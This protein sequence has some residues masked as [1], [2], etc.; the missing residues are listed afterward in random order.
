MD[1]GVS[2]SLDE[3]VTIKEEGPLST[4]QEEAA[5]EEKAAPPA[6]TAPSST[7]VSVVQDEPSKM[8]VVLDVCSPTSRVDSES[9][10]T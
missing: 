2:I 5:L 4:V 1:E 3:T 9:Q 10:E 8:S 7:P 6:P